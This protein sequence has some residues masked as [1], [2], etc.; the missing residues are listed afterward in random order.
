MHQWDI[1]LNWEWIFEV[2]CVQHENLWRWW[3]VSLKHHLHLILRCRSDVEALW[4]NQK[5][6]CCL[7][8]CVCDCIS[9]LFRSFEQF[10]WKLFDI[11]H[12][13]SIFTAFLF[14]D[15]FALLVTCLNV[16]CSVINDSTTSFHLLHALN[17]LHTL[18]R[19]FCFDYFMWSRSK[20]ENLDDFLQCIQQLLN[21]LIYA[22]TFCFMIQQWFWHLFFQSI[23]KL[24]FIHY[25]SVATRFSRWLF[26][27][28]EIYNCLYQQMIWEVFHFFVD[29]ALYQLIHNVICC[30]NQIYCH[31]RFL[32]ISRNCVL[33]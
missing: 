16:L 20:S 7:S 32:I 13:L 27:D 24:L 21:V 19:S 23:D 15:D 18:L 6:N 30:E 12:D 22:S 29:F 1:I 4:L 3:K 28:F 5:K 31:L 10:S 25:L 11:L 8:Q 26:I 2:F 17:D 33:R 9:C 14:S